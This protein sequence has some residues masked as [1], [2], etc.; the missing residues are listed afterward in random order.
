MPASRTV[1]AIETKEA[2]RPA[3]YTP[4]FHLRGKLKM[5]KSSPWL[6]G[7]AILGTFTLPLYAGSL[8]GA[9]AGRLPCWDLASAAPPDDV[10]PRRAAAHSEPG[11]LPEVPAHP[12]GTP[13]SMAESL[14]LTFSRWLT[15][16]EGCA[17]SIEFGREAVGRDRLGVAIEYML[18][19][20]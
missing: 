6:L 19:I 3:R 15:P 20:L 10:Y 16:Y 18:A 17:L 4:V 12:L 5:G 13:D 9:P 1:R 8:G 2:V 14:S 11:L 7:L